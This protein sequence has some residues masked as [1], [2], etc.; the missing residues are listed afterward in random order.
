MSQLYKTASTRD[1]QHP[2]LQDLIQS[3]GKQGPTI[4][5][6]VLIFFSLASQN[7]PQKQLHS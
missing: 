7:I 5:M 2:P 6:G 1:L 4:E 3:F